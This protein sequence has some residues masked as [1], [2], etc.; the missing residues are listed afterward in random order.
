MP[1]SGTFFTI[2]N[3]S[4]ILVL[5]VMLLVRD[6]DFERVDYEGA[7]GWSTKVSFATRL[8]GNHNLTMA[9]LL[10]VAI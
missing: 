3:Y 8:P 2:Y 10:S 9:G 7:T 6:T 1:V 5:S 4:K